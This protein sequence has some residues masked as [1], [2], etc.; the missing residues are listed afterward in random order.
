[1]L[2]FRLGGDARMTAAARTLRAAGH[3]VVDLTTPDDRADREAD[4]EA[5]W[6]LPL[7]LSRDGRTI[8]GAGALTTDEALLSIPRGALCL[9]GSAPASFCEAAA[10]RG[11]ILRDLL[12]D[13]MLVA[14]NAALTAEAALGILLTEGGVPLRGTRAALLGYGRIAR[15]LAARL[16]ACGA[17]VTVFA[18][19]EEVCAA[20]L[21]EGA[22][23]ARL[24]AALDG[25]CLAAFPLIVN[26]V[27]AP[28]LP[29]GTLATLSA[30]TFVLDLASGAPV[31]TPP[32]P[33]PRVRFAP[34][35]PGRYYP[36][37][38]GAAI[39]RAALRALG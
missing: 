34:G 8:S 38:A 31:P 28:L 22:A 14:E 15:A 30:R 19:R 36:E 35:L 11:V 7:P 26:T 5:V 3:H 21:A 32:V 10:R 12:C 24:T 13:P 6:L 17:A 4:G 18:R 23:D 39:A 27:P 16:G 2:F 33:G 29:V 1:M 20:A 9:C 37:A 25:A